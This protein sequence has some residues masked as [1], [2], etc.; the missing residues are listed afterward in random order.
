VECDEKQKSSPHRQPE[1]KQNRSKHGTLRCIHTITFCVW[2]GGLS[3]SWLHPK[4]PC[5]H[6]HAVQLLPKGSRVAVPGQLHCC[7]LHPSLPPSLSL[8]PLSNVPLS[9]SSSTSASTTMPG[10]D[11]LFSSSLHPSSIAPRDLYTPTLKIMLIAPAIL[12]SDHRSLTRSLALSLF[13]S[14][15]LSEDLHS[16]S[17]SRFLLDE[18]G[19]STLAQRAEWRPVLADI[20]SVDTV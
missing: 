4:P 11:W 19:P 2:R 1:N 10:K 7:C 3:V 6:T 8:D 15:F 14:R 17:C 16:C 20:S 12:G 18:K 5:C 13:N 9:T